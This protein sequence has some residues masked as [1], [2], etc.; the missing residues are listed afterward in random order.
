MRVLIL[1]SLLFLLVACRKSKPEFDGVNCSGNCYILTG[2]IVDTPSNSSLQGVQLKFY[3]RPVGYALFWDPTRYL[4]KTTT[5]GNGNYKFTFD[6]TKY[7][8]TQGHFI[9]EATKKGYFYDPMNQN[10][11]AN[12]YLDSAQ[13]NIPFVQNF[14]LFRSA[15]LHVR[16]QATNVT[17]FQFLTFMYYYD[18]RGTGIVLNGN[19]AIDTTVTFQT[20]GDVRTFVQWDASGNGVSIRRNDTLF[21]T[22][23]GRIQYQINL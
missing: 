11:V 7:K 16:F 21:T 8:A 3:F 18:A 12:F 9:A 6:G 5:D 19:R 2:K 20:A 1:V 14:I 4:G 23:G 15:T 17:N 13:F 22:R 10:E